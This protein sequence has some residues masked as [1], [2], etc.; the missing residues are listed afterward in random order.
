M[1]MPRTPDGEE[2][3]IDRFVSR[4]RSL[5][6]EYASYQEH[7]AEIAANFRPRRGHYI[8]EADQATVG[9]ASVKIDGQKRHH[10]IINST[11]LRVAKN[12]QSGLQAGVTSPSRPWKK[13]GPSDQQLLEIPGAR[14]AF[15][16]LDKRM[17]FVL[18]K[19]NWYRATHTAYADFVDMGPAAVQIDSHADDVIRCHTH[20]IGSW[21]AAV[22][23]DG[24]TEAF[25]RDYRPTG[26]ELRTKF[27]LGK[28]PRELQSEI[29]RDPYKRYDL[30]NAIEPNPFF[31][32]EGAPA[33]GLA[34]FPFISV[35]WVKGH[36]QDFLHTHGYYEFPVMV[37]RFYKTETG[38]AMG[39]SPGMD[40]LGDAKQLQHMEK[41]KLRAIDKMVEP[42]LQAPLALKQKGVSLVPGKV[43]YHDSQQRIESLYNVN[44]RIDYVHADIQQIERRLSETFF[45][46]LFL[47][48][49]TGVTRQVTAREIEERH[50]EK[51]IMLGPVLESI[52]DEFLDPAVDRVLGIMRRA[53]LWPQFPDD[54]EGV[55]IKVTYTSI[56]A[57]AQRAVQTISI[58][59]G[60]NFA[61][62][63]AQFKPEILDR[64]DEDGM[65]DEYFERIGFPAKAIRSVRDAKAIRDQRAQAAARQAQLE[66]GAQAAS[67]AKDANAAQ[68]LIQ[69]NILDQVIRGA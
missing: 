65:A 33:L 26:H 47:M 12:A 10:Q 32:G 54:L 53:G 16:E 5:R 44:L 62:T 34:V 38:D 27:G 4:R 57:T 68:D 8:R 9:G 15:E 40:A 64:I 67:I 48:I 11:P 55:D 58:E 37:F 21:V 66:M 69:P 17:D 3:T 2:F 39:Y 43:T 56:L 49:T 25:Y 45:E 60:F 7:Y 18:Q 30:H 61:A 19:S 59:Q 24:K 1:P 41:M 28:L 51:L 42:P 52:H 50:E 31:A 13:L 46:D 63:S 20:P 29:K 22:N 6:N 14:E 35:W 36:E 23:A